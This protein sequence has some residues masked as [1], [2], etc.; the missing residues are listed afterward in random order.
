MKAIQGFEC[1]PGI[2]P[3]KRRW[4][5]RWRMTPIIRR[6]ERR[7]QA[8]AGGGFHRRRV[9]AFLPSVLRRTPRASSLGIASR[10]R[11]TFA[12]PPCVRHPGPRWSSSHGSSTACSLRRDLCGV[13][14]VLCRP[15][16][17]RDPEGAR[18]SD[19]GCARQRDGCRDHRVTRRLP[20]G[21]HPTASV[22]RRGDWEP[23]IGETVLAPSRLRVFACET[24]LPRW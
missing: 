21:R 16:Q 14:P 2:P 24:R 15:V 20:L 5:R 17:G 4:I 6:V 3:K 11:P 10:R 7:C 23:P 8:P 13:D 1:L 19:L 18:A 9:L 22:Q 12:H